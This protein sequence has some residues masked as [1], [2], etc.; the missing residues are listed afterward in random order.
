MAALQ[1]LVVDDCRD[2]TETLVVLLELHGYRAK[3]ACS[4]REALEAVDTFVPDVLLVDIGIPRMNGFELAKR[5]CGKLS[6]RP[7]L[8]AVTGH[9]GL[10]SQSKAE[11]FDHY[12]VKPIELAALLKVLPR[13]KATEE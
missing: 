7:C 4:A 1:V 3:Q 2:F 10:E 11:A 6:S 12:F 9:T 8:I 13:L 5:L